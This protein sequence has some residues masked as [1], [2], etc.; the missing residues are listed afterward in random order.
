MAIPVDLSTK[1][2]V[3]SAV[4]QGTLPDAFSVSYLLSMSTRGIRG[5]GMEVA[6][7]FLGTK[8]SSC[9]GDEAP[10]QRGGGG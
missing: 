8:T 4:H 5:C 7:L 1:S 2:V 3:Q 6:C 10:P 9:V